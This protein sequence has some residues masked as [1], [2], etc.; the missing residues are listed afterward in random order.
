MT[1]E[2]HKD[3]TALHA[4]ASQGHMEIGKEKLKKEENIEPP[5]M[6]LPVRAAHGSVHK[7]F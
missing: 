1:E 2:G 7:F 5:C 3:W 6:L 4:A